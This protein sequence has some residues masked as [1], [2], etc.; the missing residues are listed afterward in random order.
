MGCWSINNNVNNIEKN[1]L[2]S[3]GIVV[4]E[5]GHVLIGKRPKGKIK[6]GYWEF[7]GGKIEENETAEDALVRELE[8]EMGIVTKTSCFSPFNFI[9]FVENGIGFVVLFY[10]CRVWEK[11]D[12]IKEY[13]EYKWVKPIELFDYEMLPENGNL[14]A[15]IRDFL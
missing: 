9:S 14:C 15:F 5:Y 4:D 7:P 3:C 10:I 2:I 8:E 12:I 1:I 6:E 13:C 11:S